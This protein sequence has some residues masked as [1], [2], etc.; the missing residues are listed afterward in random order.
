TGTQISAFGSLVTATADAAGTRL[1]AMAL[2]RPIHRRK[3]SE[4]RDISNDA[5]KAE[6]TQELAQAGPGKEQRINRI[7]RWVG[8]KTRV[9]LQTLR[10]LYDSDPNATAAIRASVRAGMEQLQQLNA[11]AFNFGR[12]ER[13]PPSVPVEAVAGDRNQIGFDQ[14]AAPPHREG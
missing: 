11:A 1:H 4:V 7:K 3:T 13:E 9:E 10:A 8:L 12:G 6:I 14:I 2:Y 5:A